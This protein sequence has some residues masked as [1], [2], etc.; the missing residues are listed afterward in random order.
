MLGI[1]TSNLYMSACKLTPGTPGKNGDVH[2]HGLSHQTY[3]DDNVDARVHQPA[4]VE[5]C[6]TDSDN[7]D[8]NPTFSN[9]YVN[10]QRGLHSDT[11][12]NCSEGTQRNPPHNRPC[13]NCVRNFP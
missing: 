1:P 6:H 12:N 9:P 3:R 11:R 4:N 5:Y 10:Q 13:T 8:V 2:Q 7:L